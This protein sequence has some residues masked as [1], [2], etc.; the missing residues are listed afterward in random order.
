MLVAHAVPRSFDTYRSIISIAV[1][2]RVCKPVPDESTLG[3][4]ALALKPPLDVFTLPNLQIR[5]WFFPDEGI[6]EP[7]ALPSELFLDSCTLQSVPVG[8]FL[9]SEKCLLRPSAVAWDRFLE[10]R[11]LQD[12]RNSPSWRHGWAFNRLCG[13]G[14]PHRMEVSSPV[15]YN[16]EFVELWL[17]NACGGLWDLLALGP[18]SVHKSLFPIYVHCGRCKMSLTRPWG[19]HARAFGHAWARTPSLALELPV[20]SYAF[21]GVGLVSELSRRKACS[22]VGLC[23]GA[24]SP[25]LY[26]AECAKQSL[27][28]VCSGL[29]LSLLLGLARAWE[30][31]FE[32]KGFVGFLELSWVKPCLGLRPQ[33]GFVSQPL[34]GI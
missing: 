19:S 34:Y 7:S 28:K 30:L 18:W 3:P 5:L 9:V 11:T 8:P 14:L 25:A 31:F 20:E 33:L 22:G 29:Q 13:S 21:Q 32:S 2:S 26:N 23:I 24:S 6:L 1:S 12:L 10:S 4:S 27:T 16:T 17:R 15:Q